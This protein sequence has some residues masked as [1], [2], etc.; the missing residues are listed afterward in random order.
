ME[1]LHNLLRQDAA[2]ITSSKSSAQAGGPQEYSVEEQKQ[3]DQF[4][5]NTTKLYNNQP[6]P[7]G[8]YSSLVSQLQGYQGSLGDSFVMKTLDSRRT[9][10]KIV[11]HSGDGYNMIANTFVL[12][13]QAEKAYRKAKKNPKLRN[14]S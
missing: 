13:D 12:H 9:V 7:L 10:S 14:Q 4:P 6:N 2:D 8:D 5:D 3:A 1:A 11:D